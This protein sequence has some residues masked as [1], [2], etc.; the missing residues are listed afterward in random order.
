VPRRPEPLLRTQTGE[1]VDRDPALSG[2]FLRQAAVFFGVAGHLARAGGSLRFGQE[3]VVL[4]GDTLQAGALDGSL[5]VPQVADD[6]QRRPFAG[7]G[8]LLPLASGVLLQQAE[9]RADVAEQAWHDHLRAQRARLEGFQPALAAHAQGEILE[10]TL[11]IG[12]GRAV[13][14]RCAVR[15]D[16]EGVEAGLLRRRDVI[17][18]VIA[19]HDRLIAGDTQTAHDFLVVVGSGLGEMAILNVC[20]MGIGAEVGGDA[21]PAHPFGQAVGHE[22][23]VGGDHDQVAVLAQPVQQ[24]RGVRTRLH[25]LAHADIGLRVE[26]AED[27]DGPLPGDSPFPGDHIQEHREVALDRVG[28]LRDGSHGLEQA[29]AGVVTAGH[30]AEEH[31]PVVETLVGAVEGI[32]DQR[33]VKIQQDGFDHRVLPGRG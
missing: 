21:A 15:P 7:Q 6:L 2:E 3:G 23:R 22:Q 32:G 10:G 14:G 31:V 24:D 27:L 17:L 12:M 28:V 4:A 30:P 26:G 11:A 8:M 9:E 33:I 13:A 16:P 25:I 1:E 18:P 29:E 5:A 20:H 19:D